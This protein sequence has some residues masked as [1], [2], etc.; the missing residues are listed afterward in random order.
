MNKLTALT[1]AAVFS[2][3]LCSPA[4]AQDVVISEFLADNERGLKDEDGNRNDWI[5]LRNVT[6]SAVSLTGWYLTDDSL[7]PKKWPFPAVS[8]PANGTLL[9]WAS[10]KDRRQV[11]S[12]LHTNFKLSANGEYLGL[13]RPGATA[14]STAV[15]HDYAPAYPKQFP[16]ISYGLE[17]TTLNSKIIQ[18]GTN[19]RY[20]VP[21]AG[22]LDVNYGLNANNFTVLIPPASTQWD[23][24]APWTTAALPLKFHQGTTTGQ[25]DALPG[26][27]I[28]T[29]FYNQVAGTVTRPSVYL[30]IP[31]NI[32][33]VASLS[34]VKL[35]MQIDDG[36]IAYLNGVSI[37][38]A[39]FN[40]PE[41]EGAA[42]L[43][44]NQPAAAEFTNA[45]STTW[46]ETLVDKSLLR[47][48]ENIL[49]IHAFNRA[50][51]NVD[52]LCWPEMELS[53]SNAG[54]SLTSKQ[55][56]RVATPNT[57]N[58]NGVSN[59]GPVI[60]ETTEN[61]P[62][63]TVPALGAAVA[64][65]VTEFSGNQ[66]QLGW[67]YGWADYGSGVAGKNVYNP[68][69]F[70]QFAG[71]TTAGAWAAGTNFW[72]GTLWDH[73]TAAAAPW[74]M[75]SNT[76]TH[77]SDSNPA[78]QQLAAS[79]RRWTSDVTGNY[80]LA[81]FFQRAATTGDGSTGHLF[82]NGVSVFSGLTVGDFRGFQVP[83]TLAVGD[84]I[85]MVVDVGPA[86]EDAS[87]NT[88]V[89]LRVI[90]APTT[91][92]V[93]QKI[94]ARVGQSVQPLA[95]VVCK[96]RVLNNGENTLPMADNGMNGDAVAGDGIFTCNADITL[97]QAGQ[98]LRWRIVATDDAGNTTADPPYQDIF[99]DPQ[100]Y[101][102]MVADASTSTSQLPVLHW[103]PASLANSATAA[104]DRGSVYYLGQFYDNVRSKLHG[105]STVGFAKKS[106]GL[107]FA[108][109]QRFQYKVGEKRVRDVL[110]L[111]NW[112]DK[113]KVRN[114]IAW[115][116]YRAAGTPA[117]FAFPVRVHQSGQFYGVFDMVEDADDIYLERAGLK[118]GALYKMYNS[119]NNTAGAY[120]GVEKKSRQ[121][122]NNADLNALN[123]ALNTA[124]TINTRRQY[125]YDNLNLPEL[126]NNLAVTALIINQDQGHKNYFLYR[127][128]EGTREWTILPWD[129]DLTFG[130]TWTGN[131]LNSTTAA[132][133][134]GASYFDDH[135]DSQRGLRLGVENWV[136]NIMYNQPEFNKM[137]LRRLRTL[138]DEW[139]IDVNATSGFFE[140]RMAQILDTIEPPALPLNQTD[141]WLD[142]QRWGLWWT[143]L[144]W[145]IQASNA[146]A[147]V[148]STATTFSQMWTLHGPRGS[149]GRV[150]NP[151]GNP[152]TTL[153]ADTT[154]N[155]ALSAY[156]STA[157][158]SL[159]AATVTTNNASPNNL[160]NYDANTY[161]PFGGGT[162]NQ[163]GTPATYRNTG[164]PQTI[165]PFL[166][167]RRLRLYDTTATRPLSGTAAIPS[168]QPSTI[169][170]TFDSQEVNPGLHGGLKQDAEF[171]ILK[172]NETTEVDISGWKLTGAVEYTF[173]G[174]CVI[175]PAADAASTL[176]NKE[177]LGL[178]HVARSPYHFRQ[179]TT[180]PRGNQNR[181]VVG[182]Y[183]GQLSARG[184]VIELRK[185]DN[186]LVASNAYA[187]APTPMQQALRVV[188]VMYAP[189]A[190]TPAELAAN[191][192]L[193]ASDF[194][195]LVLE[196]IGNTTL[197]LTGATFT[198]GLSYTF[199]T[200]SLN[201]GERVVLAANPAAFAL[202]HPGY[203]GTVVGGFLGDLNNGGEQIHLVDN[204]GESILEFTYDGAWYWP[205]DNAG[206]SLKVVDR[207]AAYTNW[208]NVAHWAPSLTEG[209]L[210]NNTGMV[211]D[212]FRRAEFTATQQ[213]NAAVSGPDADED[214]DGISN[215]IEYSAA[216]DPNTP[217]SR[218]LPTHGSVTVGTDTFATISFRRH[219]T[220]L[221]LEYEPIAS[222]DLT[223]W[224]SLQDQVGSVVDNGDGTET[225]TFR[226]AMPTTPTQ[227]RYVT[228][229]VNLLGNP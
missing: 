202:R 214:H 81:G 123:T 225:V 140:T 166:K 137:F 148:A 197:D 186:T 180:G 196:N 53:E 21:S 35:R 56:F 49:S 194:E 136:K 71:G 83:V 9:V 6:G 222:S 94:T 43:F 182:P 103:F 70:Q 138:M 203:V 25:Y 176:P 31:F 18:A 27:D 124:V 215:L 74:T 4:T 211:Y 171:F 229:R 162:T 208:D 97:A 51:N 174:G 165:H 99:N 151:N 64:D 96:F 59:P 184:E 44:W 147:T 12:P 135:I 167:G 29:T 2:L 90:P 65:S 5:E 105:Q 168:A 13:M 55:F 213:M 11:G 15:E 20:L 153:I 82:H 34:T 223:S 164:A 92:P 66:G 101:G 219:K 134:I 220:A 100:Y 129:C 75:H 85:D 193:Q 24:A 116:T 157:C 210:T 10:E 63:P 104:G 60:A 199:G 155:A 91:P 154:N 58:V 119:F 195:F 17:Q 152:T 149:L 161:P 187:A 79:V 183:K 102:T 179:R 41:N 37:P 118:G 191:N 163:G 69:A 125:A 52:F 7:R 172:N 198:E 30:R 62:S 38:I 212:Q 72:T 128:T 160:L 132:P 110:L 209:G 181:F 46:Q 133:Q 141:S 192:V 22:T 36:Y 146:S 3:S 114:T 112:A 42:V 143:A 84:R 19:C 177:N 26:T 144:P 32:T 80:I 108:R 16:N 88:S 78:T 206:H 28:E 227:R 115:E 221:D 170:I 159:G 95:S 86:N 113:A 175:P 218:L 139:L 106:L 54:P 150:I 224:D 1:S 201:A 73:N 109:D 67:S 200:L 131:T 204:V 33:N 122:E 185:P 87:D 8:I 93:Y 126:A 50:N 76:A 142:G 173:P 120:S 188:E 23:Q 48:G 156:I 226:D 228:L 207:A 45:I 61:P 190:P 77:P 217:V 178:L 68:D 107:D 158:Y 205:A 169:N 39:D 14:G 145:K 121:E 189:L 47:N 111:S 117:L 127:D 216:G 57:A 89:Q 130:H 98:S 40:G